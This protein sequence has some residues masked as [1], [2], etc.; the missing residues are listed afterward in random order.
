LS[1]SKG[2][3]DRVLEA[4]NF[5]STI[6]YSIANNEENKPRER[7]EGSLIFLRSEIYINQLKNNND[8]PK[9]MEFIRKELMT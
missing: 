2:E 1:N 4:L 3:N 5:V 8:S 6:S 7:L 9:V